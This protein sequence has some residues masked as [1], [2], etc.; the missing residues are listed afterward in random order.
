MYIRRFFNPCHRWY[1]FVFIHFIGNI[2][3]IYKD[4]SIQN[5]IEI[6]IKV[7]KQQTDEALES[8]MFDVI[9]LH[10]VGKETSS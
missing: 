7:E 6:A 10:Q 2:K 8:V 5:K 3:N 1:V 4:V 9:K